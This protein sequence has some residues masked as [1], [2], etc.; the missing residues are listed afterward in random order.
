MTIKEAIINEF[1]LKN[2]TPCI[3][4]NV[5]FRAPVRN[6]KEFYTTEQ[7]EYLW[8]HGML[9]KYEKTGATWENPYEDYWQFTNKGH[10]WRIWYTT[11]LWTLI[12]IYVLHTHVLKLKWDV[13]KYKLFGIRAGWMDYSSAYG[14]EDWDGQ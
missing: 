1:E 8:T 4:P 9:E 11:D 5:E 3:L 12:K 6:Y 13:L 14:G 7:L 2:I 10:R